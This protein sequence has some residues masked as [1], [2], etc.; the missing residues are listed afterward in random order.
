[1]RCRSASPSSSDLTNSSMHSSCPRPPTQ[2]RRANPPSRHY[3]SARYCRPTHAQ[4]SPAQPSAHDRR[5]RL[6][7]GGTSWEAL[8]STQCFQLRTTR[9]AVVP[10]AHSADEA[11]TARA[12]AQSRVACCGAGVRESCA[13]VR[14]RRQACVLHAYGCVGDMR[15][16]GR[17]GTGLRWGVHR[18]AWSLHGR[19]SH[20][21]AALPILH[22]RLGPFHTV[23]HAHT[24]PPLARGGIL[25]KRRG[26][27]QRRLKGS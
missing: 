9:S 20:L 1:L 7:V 25:L 21:R 26:G 12:H 11:D 5:G 16:C 17:T 22:D 19:G 18:G 27:Q 14:A 23:L 8:R 6:P 3:H 2:S 13:C 24:R 15:R 4:A 10:A